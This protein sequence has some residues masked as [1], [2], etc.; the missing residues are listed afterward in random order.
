MAKPIGMLFGIVLYGFQHQTVLGLG[1]QFPLLVW[2]TG[3]I[4]PVLAKEFG[5]L[6]LE[7]PKVNSI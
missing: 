2:A 6:L 3:K 7:L 5:F 1:P 4:K